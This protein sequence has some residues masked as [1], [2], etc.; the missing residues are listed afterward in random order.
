[1]RSVS[2]CRRPQAKALALQEHTISVPLTK[3]SFHGQQN[4]LLDDMIEQ[5]LCLHLPIVMFNGYQA[6]KQCRQKAWYIPA[7]KSSLPNKHRPAKKA[8]FQIHGITLICWCISVMWTRS[9]FSAVKSFDLECPIIA[10]IDSF[11]EGHQSGF[12]V[13][14]KPRPLS[15]YC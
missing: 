12:K 15:I 1:M 7:I 6:K 4:C 9:S 14:C 5:I 13:G 2:R 3:L 8:Q 10:K 11:A